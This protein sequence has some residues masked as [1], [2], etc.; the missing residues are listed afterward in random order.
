MQTMLI[1]CL[2]CF[3]THTGM[4]AEDFCFVAQENGLIVQQEG[5]C[6]MRRS[7]CSTFKIALSVIG[8][9]A[10]ILIDETHPKVPFRKEYPHYRAVW[11]Q[12]H[13][14][15]L[16]IQNSCLWFSQYITHRLGLKKLKAYLKKLG[17]GNQKIQGHK[18]DPDGLKKS[19]ISGSLE[20]SPLEQIDF[21]QHLYDQSLPL[22]KQAQTM[23]K[24]ILNKKHLSNGWILVSKT[25]SGYQVGHNPTSRMPL[26]Q[27]WS[28]GWIKNGQRT[29]IYAYFK[30][31]NQ[32]Y[33][34]F[35]GERIEAE[36][37]KKLH[38]LIEGKT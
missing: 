28:V 1:T 2:L 12:A 14:P 20:I 30:K 35:A 8:F 21:L 9:D 3:L 17:Y 32:F 6:T 13:H 33:K 4:W 11:R 15:R 7:P 23:T 29:I 22:R 26:K 5:N 37:I 31:E 18:N 24:N 25:G 16:W 10:G 38:H 36:A 27:G 19:W 34:G